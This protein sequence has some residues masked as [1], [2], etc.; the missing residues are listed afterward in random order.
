MGFSY[1]KETGIIGKGTNND[2]KRIN[3]R[4]NSDNVIYNNGKFDVLKIGE[5]LNFTNNSNP[6]VRTGNIYWNDMHN[7]LVTTP[8]LPMNAENETDKAYPYHY[9][10]TWNSSESNPIA[11]MIY[12]TKNSTNTGNKIMGKVYVELQPLKK[13]IYRSSLGVDAWFGNSRSYTVPFELSST[14]LATVDK[15]T[16]SMN[17]GYTWTFTNTLSYD[18][19]SGEHNIT[20]LIGSEAIK[21]AQSLS[22]STSN[23][24]NIFEDWEH[25]Y[26]DNATTLTSNTTISGKDDYGWGMM[27]YF[28]RLSYDY[29]ETYL[30]TA[31]MRADASSNFTDRNRWGYFPSFSAGWVA[32]NENF[33]KNIPAINFLKIRGSWGQNG[34]QDIEPFQFLSTLSF[35]NSRYSFG[36]DKTAY[37]LGA[38]PAI[39]PNPDIKWETSEQLDLGFDVHF[40]DSRLQLNFD[41]Y[42]KTTKDWLVV[43]PAL[44]SYGTDPAF[45]NGGTI[46]NK[47][48][49]VVARWQD[50]VGNLNYS[51]AVSYANN[52][53]EVTEI[54]NEEKII[55]GENANSVLSQGMAELYRAEVGYPIGYFWGYETDGIIQNEAEV[56]AYVGGPDNT[57]YFKD[58]KPG[59]VRFVDKNNDGEISDLDKVMLGDP[60]PDH[61]LGLQLNFDYKGAYL[62]LTSNGQFGQQVAMAYHQATGPTSN[63]STDIYE[64]RWHG[65]GTSNVWPLLSLKSHRNLQY[66]SDLYIYNADFFR[67]S[68]VTIGYDLKKL[69][70]KM[71]LTEA[72]VYVSGKNLHTFTKYPGMDPEVGYGPDKWASGI[73]VGL[74][75]SARTYL[76][77]VSLTF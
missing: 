42:N 15:V 73:D 55:H 58:A 40:L 17:Q 11:N 13:L 12:N 60:N 45:I 41:W 1:L 8:L 29:K 76:V 47:G 70:T 31:V 50:K 16:Q 75:P 38:Y 52:N 69:F 49:E 23:E 67:I 37:Q 35:E 61:I 65:E 32:S 63:Y 66:V 10:V 3:F 19:T 56:A 62:Q 43:A 22:M 5:T 28:G 30:F 68:N 51:I 26:I 54:K 2:Y 7:A 74:Y 64:Q 46:V 6:T 53:N 34:N 20:G 44:A 59:D 48:L 39:L 25:A 4:L 33:V 27:S 24:G 71:P 36:S 21:N 77:G 57:P 9:A 18:F 14:A 72:R